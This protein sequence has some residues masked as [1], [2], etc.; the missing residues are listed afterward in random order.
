MEKV[1]NHL[2]CLRIISHCHTTR[3]CEPHKLFI[4]L[5]NGDSS[6]L[7][8]SQRACEEEK[9]IFFLYL[10]CPF[11]DVIKVSLLKF[12]FHPSLSAIYGKYRWCMWKIDEMEKRNYH[13]HLPSFCKVSLSLT[14]WALWHFAPFLAVPWHNMLAAN[15]FTFRFLRVTLLTN[16]KLYGPYTNRPKDEN[17]L[18][19]CMCRNLTPSMSREKLS[20]DGCCA[21]MRNK[22]SRK[23]V[24][25]N[26]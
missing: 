8:R 16:S 5:T 18:P 21:A 10:L 26:K 3:H 7:K 13:L 20:L 14:H 25:I 23:E 9:K 24:Q 6:N 2:I 1:Y 12:F 15:L 11:R 19:L 22:L 4:I 17:H